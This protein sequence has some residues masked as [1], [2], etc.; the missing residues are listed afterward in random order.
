MRVEKGHRCTRGV[1]YYNLE[2]GQL[3]L[4]SPPTSGEVALSGWG[5]SYTPK[6]GFLGQDQFIVAFLAI[7]KSKPEVRRS[8]LLFRWFRLTDA[9]RQN[10]RSS[11]GK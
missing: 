9:R 5:F 11:L 4:I 8:E 6:E 10:A 1:R 3:K 7:S 2:L